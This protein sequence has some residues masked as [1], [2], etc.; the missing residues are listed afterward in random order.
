M[1]WHADAFVSSP[2]RNSLL[3]DSL[4]LFLLA[5]STLPIPLRLISASPPSL[6]S[7]SDWHSN[8]IPHRVR[9]KRQRLPPSLLIE[10]ASGRVPI[11]CRGSC[12]RRFRSS[13]ATIRPETRARKEYA[14]LKCC[15]RLP[16]HLAH[17]IKN[18]RAVGHPAIHFSMPPAP[19][20]ANFIR[21]ESCTRCQRHLRGAGAQFV[22]RVIGGGLPMGG[23]LITNHFPSGPAS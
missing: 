10:N 13:L 16:T 8:P 6:D 11:R 9:R 3:V 20:G 12:P 2:Y 19:S 7:I 22:I 17:P 4:I 15:S 21:P 14:Q 23:E 5:A 1:P 18:A